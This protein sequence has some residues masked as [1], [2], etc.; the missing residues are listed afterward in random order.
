[1]IVT[2]PDCKTRYKMNAALLES[3]GRRLKC[4][5]CRATWFQT[6]RGQTVAE[7]AGEQPAGFDI[8][9]EAE[10]LLGAARQIDATRLD[11]AVDIRR[12][13][14]GW[15]SLTG[16]VGMF[17]I[18]SVMFRHAIVKQ[19]PATYELYALAGFKVNIRG[20]EF[21]N[22]VYDSRSVNGIPVLTVSGEI[23]N[24]SGKVMTVPK[25]RFSLQDSALQEIYHW[26]I[27]AKPKALAVDRRIKFATRLASPPTEAQHVQVRFARAP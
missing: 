17:V 18:S 15:L 8:E 27:A 20:L 10:R 1:M 16:C 5:S 21:G 13:L 3:Q 26:Q 4:K 11:R 14:L 19:F 25:I 2:C 9:S 22:V 6:P 23:L 7:P 12:K 24:V